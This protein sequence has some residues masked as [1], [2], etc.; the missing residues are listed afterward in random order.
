MTVVLLGRDL[1]IA[2]RVFAAAARAGVEARRVDDPAQLPPPDEVRF[3]LV[4]W[5][6]RSADW[7]EALSRWCARAPG[8]AQPKVVLFGP[9][10]DLAAHA[11]ARAAG[12][13]PMWARS[14]FLADLP[15]LF[16]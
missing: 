15:T 6:D 14:K 11:S 5:A 13:G 3:L 2:S 7:A 9:H 10:V 16:D 12:L 4:D 8:S 1:I